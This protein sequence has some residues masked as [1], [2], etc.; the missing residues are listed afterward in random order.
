MARRRSSGKKNSVSFE[1]VPDFLNEKVTSNEKSPL[2]RRRSSANKEADRRESLV[3]K[4]DAR[5][6]EIAN[7]STRR[8]SEM[9]RSYGRYEK[10]KDTPDHLYGLDKRPVSSDEDA[11]ID[12]GDVSHQHSSIN[13]V[14]LKGKV[15]DFFQNH[16]KGI[17][18]LFLMIFIVGLLTSTILQGKLTVILI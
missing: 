11:D 17:S 12:I 18:G 15:N 1:K 9:A 2:Q 14:N 8:S 4:L 6:S 7:D 10:L 13:E 3:N 5:R 16:W